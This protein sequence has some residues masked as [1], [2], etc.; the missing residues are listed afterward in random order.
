MPGMPLGGPINVGLWIE[1]HAC[2]RSLALSNHK[3]TPPLKTLCK[4]NH[5]PAIQEKANVKQ[6]ASGNLELLG[7]FLGISLL[8]CKRWSFLYFSQL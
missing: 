7:F 6:T 2:I 1:F 8:K 3:G 4:E 5:I